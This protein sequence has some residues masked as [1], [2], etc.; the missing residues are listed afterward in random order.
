MCQPQPECRQRLGFSGT[1][2]GYATTQFRYVK[3]CPEKQH[4]VAGCTGKSTR[5]PRRNC[6]AAPRQ[7]MEMEKGLR[8]GSAPENTTLT[9]PRADTRC[10]A[11]CAKAAGPP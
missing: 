10:M 11:P 2:G 9:A 7:G 6:D 5:W 4:T 8:D 1:F 3:C